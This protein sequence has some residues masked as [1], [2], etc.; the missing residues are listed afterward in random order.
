M[1][2]SFEAFDSINIMINRVAHFRHQI[3]NAQGNPWIFE[4]QNFQAISLSS[5]EHP[6]GDNV[7]EI[8]C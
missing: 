8:E 1:F 7:S 4:I 3:Q 6:A 5:Y 2:K